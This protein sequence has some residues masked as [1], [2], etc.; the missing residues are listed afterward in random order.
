MFPLSVTTLTVYGLFGEVTLLRMCDSVSP[1]LMNMFMLYLWWCV[2]LFIHIETMWE[3]RGPSFLK[4]KSVPVIFA[5]LNSIQSTLKS[6]GVPAVL[7]PQIF[8]FQ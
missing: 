2:E 5:T 4:M 3:V 7:T 8:I 1:E 6:N